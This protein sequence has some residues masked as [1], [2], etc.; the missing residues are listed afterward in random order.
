MDNL[1]IFGI[2]SNM[3]TNKKIKFMKDDIFVTENS[4]YYCLE[5]SVVIIEFPVTGT[6]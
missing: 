4:P 3:L 5:S 1:K 6:I 2:I